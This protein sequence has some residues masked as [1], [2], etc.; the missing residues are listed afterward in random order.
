MLAAM[1]PEEIA[2]CALGAGVLLGWCF[3]T[4]LRRRDHTTFVFARAPQLPVRALAAHDDAWLRGEV[5]AAEPLVCPWFDVRC[6]AYSYQI[7]KKVTRTRKDEKGNTVTETSWETEH[8]ESESID[9]D[10]HDG[11]TVRVALT[12]GDNEAMESTGTDYQGSSRRHSANVL[13]IGATVSALGVL[14]DDRTFGPMAEV[15][16]LVTSAT[17]EERV[18]ASARSEGW[19]FFFAVFFPWAGLTVAAALMLRAQQWPDWLPAAAIGLL[20]VVPQWWLL[21]YNR[22]VR[23][24]QQVKTAQKQTHVELALRADLVPNLVAVV[25]GYA[26]HERD[27]LERLAAIRV[28]RDLDQE[29]REERATVATTRDV[30]LLHERHPQLRSDALYRDLHERLWAVEEKLAH[31][32]SFYNDVVTEWNDRIA[33]FPSSLVAAACRHQPAPLFAAACEE[34][35]PPRLA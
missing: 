35:L 33:S 14:R 11:E 18:R 29:V 7:E 28:G 32:R 20:A 27:L 34:K 26:A 19:F 1:T 23:L 5:Q 6:V 4:A 8:T 13:P 31:A 10:L 30:L 22:L 25:Q 12:E 15:P 9:F 2:A 16:L 24:R 17:R 21:T 3:A